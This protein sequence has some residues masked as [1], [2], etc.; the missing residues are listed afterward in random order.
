MT[1][2]IMAYTI[3]RNSKKLLK[4]RGSSVSNIINIMVGQL[5]NPR[6]VYLTYAYHV[7]GRTYDVTELPTDYRR[8]LQMTI[9][10]EP[11]G[12][13]K[14]NP[15]WATERLA[16]VNTNARIA[17]YQ[18]EQRGKCGSYA[19]IAMNFSNSLDFKGYS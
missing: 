12:W 2:Q 6:K 1:H 3:T 15:T 4:E 13:E 17:D 5:P 16:L 19:Q 10:I 9:G 18:S 7:V 14:V 8:A 11:M